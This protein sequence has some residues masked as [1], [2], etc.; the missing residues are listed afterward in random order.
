MIRAL[1]RL[2]TAAGIAAV[3]LDRAL[4]DPE[5]IVTEI[6]IAR[7]IDEVWAE[8]ADL[9]GQPRW[10]TDLKSVRILTPGPIG[11][12]TR[13]EGLVR[14]LGIP[15]PDPVEIIEWDPPRRFAIRHLGQFAG[16]GVITLDADPDRT[17]T[18]V[19]WEERLRAPILPH[20]AGAIL[21]P[22][23]ARVFAADLARLRRRL[24]G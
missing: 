13:A 6:T 5:P 7:P 22:I 20:L 12:G 8:L 3:L 15:M 19:R 23:L 24:E 1:V 2:G 14:I 9:E 10:M 18:H 17:A 16:E 4:A 21:H 11:L